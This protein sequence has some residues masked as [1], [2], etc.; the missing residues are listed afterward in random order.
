MLLLTCLSVALGALPDDL[1]AHSDAPIWSSLDTFTALRLDGPDDPRTRSETDAALRGQLLAKSKALTALR[2]E[3][4][5][6]TE[7]HPRDREGLAVLALAHQDMA[8]AILGSHVPTYLTDD[9]REAYR[10]ALDDKAYPQ[11]EEAVSAYT[12]LAS[13]GGCDA[14]TRYALRAVARLR[15]GMY[16]PVR[17]VRPPQLSGDLARGFDALACGDDQQ[18]ESL[19]TGDAP[20]AVLGRAVAAHYL[21]DRDAAARAF[22]G[23]LAEHPGDPDVAANAA[24]FYVLATRD[25]QAAAQV[26]DAAL[27]NAAPG[28]PIHETR[29]WLIDR[30]RG[31]A[32]VAQE[33]AAGGAVLADLGARIAQMREVLAACDGEQRTLG[34]EIV[35]RAEVIWTTEDVGMAREMV[36]FLEDNILQMESECPQ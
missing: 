23:L 3:V 8:E 34:E 16:P 17:V 14:W 25:V 9:Q 6:Y 31:A 35:S 22:A 10:W 30:Q 18:A 7:A 26:L 2:D 4:L 20:A 1:P 5:V 21:G 36:A 29:A 28:H 13:R 15:P 33:A 12:M 11:E 27:P 32:A 19:F 24:H